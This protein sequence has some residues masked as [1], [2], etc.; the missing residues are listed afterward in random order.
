MGKDKVRKCRVCGFTNKDCNVCSL[1]DFHA[2]IEK[3][4]ACYWV[5]DDLCS[6]CQEEMEKRKVMPCQMKDVAK[7]VIVHMKQLSIAC[8]IPFAT[9]Y[10]VRD[11]EKH[12]K[13]ALTAHGHIIKDLVCIGLSE[14]EHKIYF[15]FQAIR[16]KKQIYKFRVV[17]TFRDRI[18]GLKRG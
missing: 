5:E 17:Y 18:S 3:T 16:L 11:V 10:S 12:V 2:C 4:G 7:K 8:G 15:E 1:D 6:A 14:Q 9:M 13:M